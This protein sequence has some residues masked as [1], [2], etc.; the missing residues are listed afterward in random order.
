MIITPG[1]LTQRSEFY[2]QLAQ[3]TAAGIGV[4]AA[5]EQI[6]RNPP[7]RYFRAP[8]QH[9]LDELAR[10]KTLSE[11]LRHADWLPEFDLSL[12]EAGERSGRLDSCF[13]LLAEYYN[14][15]AS[16]TKQMIAQLIYPA[17]LIHFAALVFLVIIPFASPFGSSHF[18]ANL[19]WLLVRA[20]LF[21]SPL[22]AAVALLIYAMQ[23][24]HGE[25]WRSLIESF[26]RFFPLL[27]TARRFL[28]LS[29]LAAALEAL[30]NA[31]V[32]IVE[33][34]PL[35]ATASAS[36]ALRRTVAAWKPEF[37]AGRTPSELIQ[38]SRIFPESFASLYVSGEMSGKLDETL[39]RLHV[40]YQEEGTHKLQLAAQWGPR[41]VYFAVALIVSYKVIQFY[42]GYFNQVNSWSHF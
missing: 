36:P 42:T 24:K 2:H 30:I 19:V 22:Y 13:R 23:S 6:K 1:H 20:A 27:G 28:A 12:I 38:S 21:L 41:L 32:G 33:A 14:N 31:G 17:I 39:R 25:K 11:S 3:L 7:G 26:L 4:T 18:S 8:L 35:S 40:Y 37:A 29:R 34:W 9:F 5:L 16:L 15:R 10:G